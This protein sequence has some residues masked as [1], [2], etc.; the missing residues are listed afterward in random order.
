MVPP[1]T[2]KPKRKGLPKKKKNSSTSLF[3]F[4]KDITYEKK[5]ILNNDNKSGYSKFMIVKFLS[6][7]PEYIPLV[8]SYLNRYAITLG[9]EEFH[10]LCIALIPK[11]NVYLEYIGGKESRGECRDKLKYIIDFFEVSE[12]QAYEYYL[13]AGDELVEDIKNL[14]G[15]EA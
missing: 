10:K 15:G 6:M 3:D 12:D 7:R 2:T 14:Y 5:N 8:D 13:I 1:R 4:L 11:K 9:D